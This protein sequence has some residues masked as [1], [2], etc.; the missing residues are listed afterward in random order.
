MFL[1]NEKCGTQAELAAYKTQ[2]AAA[3]PILCGYIRERSSIH[4]GVI[5]EYYLCGIQATIDVEEDARPGNFEQT[6]STPP[7]LDCVNK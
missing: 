7:T 2:L 5:S 3:N 6:S 4:G 1:D